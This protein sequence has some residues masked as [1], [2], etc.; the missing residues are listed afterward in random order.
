MAQ[1]DSSGITQRT[2]RRK[3]LNADIADTLLGADLSDRAARGGKAGFEILNRDR[4]LGVGVEG[5]D[6]GLE[7][8]TPKAVDRSDVTADACKFGL[9]GGHRG[10][11]DV[12][13]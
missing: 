13:G 8:V 4:F 7:L 12:G 1:P 2:V 10:I 5:I 9:Q 11:A 3:A 6:P